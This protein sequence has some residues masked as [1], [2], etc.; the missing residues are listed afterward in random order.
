[1]KDK[2]L[3]YITTSLKLCIFQYSDEPQATP[4]QIQRK[5]KKH[6]KCYLHS[7]SK[8]YPG[9]GVRHYS[10]GWNASNQQ[11][12]QLCCQEPYILLRG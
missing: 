6:L 2:S 5:K 8:Y 10:R 12:R 9:S 7:F 1:M 3:V 11:K 4:L